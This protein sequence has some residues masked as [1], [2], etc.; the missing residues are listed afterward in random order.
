LSSLSRCRHTNSLAKMRSG[1]HAFCIVAAM[2]SGA[3]A[4]DA[5]PARKTMTVSSVNVCSTG[6]MQSPINLKTCPAKIEDESYNIPQE[7]PAIQLSYGADG[8]EVERVCENTACKASH[9]KIT[10]KSP[11]GSTAT[12]MMEVAGAHHARQYAL[13]HCT[14]H[15][16]AE[17]SVDG[18][19]APLE[20]QCHHVME[21]T[22]HKRK[23]MLST[24]YMVGK[25]ASS[26][27]GAFENN[28]PS[29]A[30]FVGFTTVKGPWTPTGSAG[31]T[32]YHSYKGSQTTGDCA[33]DVDWFV[34]Y[35]PTGASQAQ[36]D[37]LAANMT[38][39]KARPL[40]E[41][42]GREPEACPTHH[43]AGNAHG[44]AGLSALTLAA[45]L[46]LVSFA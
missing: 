37:K 40:Q 19:V 38:W 43:E 30:G 32:R 34:M 20:V 9:L 7:R 21:H 14:L 41:L 11:T 16:P 28:L 2:V 39:K 12:N 33:E 1:A 17:H 26:F 25:S 23:G 36:L 8:M 45:T 22:G 27:I 42:Y 15:M 46:L 31:L 13:D 35:D 10:P 6:V 5:A 24:L 18:R 3:F 44:A 4:N 29:K